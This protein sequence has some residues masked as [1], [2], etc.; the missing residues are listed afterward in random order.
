MPEKEK[1]WFPAKRYGFG[2]GPPKCWQGWLVFLAYFGLI[3]GGAWFFLERN[4][5]PCFLTYVAALSLGLIFVCW[6]KGEPPRWR[7]GRD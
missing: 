7:W 6:W 3:G 1:F 4:L 2:W 5:I